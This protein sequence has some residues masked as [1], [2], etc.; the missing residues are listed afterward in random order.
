[1]KRVFPAAIA[2][3]VTLT[4]AG[5][6]QAQGGP[7]MMSGTEYVFTGYSTAKRF[8]D[9]GYTG[10]N[11]ACQGDFGSNARL[12]TTEEFLTAPV[13]APPTEDAWIRVTLF[14]TH[15]QFGEALFLIDIS[16]YPNEARR[17]SCVGWSSRG[18]NISGLM[19]NN[20]GVLTIGACDVQRPV[21]C[22]VPAIGPP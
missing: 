15:I 3:L 6:A 21:A 20:D 12:A 9:G 7:P 19:I 5:Q 1:M 18:H 10:R 16:G 11:A 17:M 4:F 2:V 13:A 8:G 14:N 22:S